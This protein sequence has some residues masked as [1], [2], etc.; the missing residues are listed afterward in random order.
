MRRAHLLRTG[1]ADTR[2]AP[3][4]CASWLPA[5]DHTNPS[6][7]LEMLYGHRL[8]GIFGEREH[9]LRAA[10]AGRWRNYLMRDCRDAIVTV[11]MPMQATRTWSARL[12]ANSERRWPALHR[13][14]WLTCTSLW[15]PGH[16]SVLLVRPWLMIQ[17]GGY[18]GSQ[19]EYVRVP[20][21]DH[22]VSHAPAH[23]I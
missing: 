7:Q 22:N 11:C 19:A 20:L 21:A 6:G 8:A 5:G 10:V 13:L 12:V 2:Y 15:L 4:V 3:C 16:A 23:L 18:S 9:V 17:T 14:Q 1:F